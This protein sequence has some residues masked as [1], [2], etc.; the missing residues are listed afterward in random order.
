MHSNS[1]AAYCLYKQKRSEIPPVEIIAGWPLGG[2]NEYRNAS[3]KVPSDIAYDA[4]GNAHCGFDIPNG[5]DKLQWVKL[6]LEPDL[7][8]KR[9]QDAP[10]VQKSLA[11]LERLE[12]KPVDVVADYLHWLWIRIQEKIKEDVSDDVFQKVATAIIMTIPA[13]WSDRARD[14]MVQAAERAGIAGND[15]AVLKFVTEPE[16]A[17]IAGLRAKATN[18]QISAQD[19]VI[20]CDAGGGT[21]DVVTYQVQSDEPLILSQCVA[22]DGD[23]CGSVFVDLEFQ[24]QLQ[25]FLQDDV[26]RLADT[27][28][29]DIMETFE[30]KIKP[31]YDP[32]EQRPRPC[33]LH[34][35]GVDADA[36][37][38]IKNNTLELDM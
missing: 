7:S 4:Q 12:K 13:S 26:D 19:C 6:L 25:S 27:A 32:L 34:V 15:E 10:P 31:S 38:K 22:A 5:L 36:N 1:G 3:F 8:R 9:F 29:E 11:I 30:Y 28:V 33:Y 23:L 17:A 20:V 16:A 2:T 37:R 14:S 35:P 21:V 24:N 18:G